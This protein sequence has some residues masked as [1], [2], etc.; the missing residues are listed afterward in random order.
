[1]SGTTIVELHLPSDIMAALRSRQRMPLDDEDRVKLSLAIGLYADGTISLAKAAGLA[2]MSRYE[3]A[4]FLKSKGVPARLCGRSGI[5]E[6]HGGALGEPA[7]GR[8]ECGTADL[9]LLAG[10]VARS[11]GRLRQGSMCQM[12][13]MKRS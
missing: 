9:S 5:P 12:R 3:F 13:S 4:M 1:M 2:G 10:K 8:H 6:F 7:A 11:E